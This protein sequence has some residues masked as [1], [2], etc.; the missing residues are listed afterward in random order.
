MFTHT[1]DKIYATA[2]ALFFFFSFGR[3]DMVLSPNIRN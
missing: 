3:A 1:R 2:F